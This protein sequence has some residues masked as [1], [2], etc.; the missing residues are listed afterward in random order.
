[1]KNEVEISKLQKIRLIVLDVDGTLTDGK[2]YLDEKESGYKAYS[3]K[4]GLVL[5]KWVEYGG[6]TAIITGRVSNM[7]ER[8]ARELQIKHIEQGVRNKSLTL[9]KILSQEKIPYEAVCYIGDDLNDLGAMMKVGFSAAPADAA[10]EVLNRVD[11]VSGKAGGFG[12]VREIVVKIM[13]AQE[14]WEK[15]IRDFLME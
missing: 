5:S 8:R 1:M 9:E 6:M 11:F 12:A 3:A 7:V 13:K 4:D 10:T 14:N 2:I 15:V